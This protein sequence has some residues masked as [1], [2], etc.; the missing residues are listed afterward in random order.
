M[1]AGRKDFNLLEALVFQPRLHKAHC[2]IDRITPGL[3]DRQ[4]HSFFTS[5]RLLKSPTPTAS[6]KPPEMRDPSSDQ[7]PFVKKPDFFMVNPPLQ[8]SEP[9]K[10]HGGG[11]GIDFLNS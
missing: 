8:P 2:Q 9:D 1:L 6:P 3:G 11:H 4:F 7:G 5:G 10:D